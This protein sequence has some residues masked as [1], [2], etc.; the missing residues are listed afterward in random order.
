[1]SEQ[2]AHLW[3]EMNQNPTILYA[4]K[5]DLCKEFAQAMKKVNIVDN[6]MD[7]CDDPYDS[8]LVIID[9]SID[10]KTPLMYDLTF[11]V[12]IQMYARF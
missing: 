12:R 2:L 6:A 8:Y 4:Y 3:K 9:R 7:R 11:Q 10:T 5:S 1:M